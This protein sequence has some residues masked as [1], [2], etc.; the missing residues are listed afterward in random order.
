MGA[1]APW[2]RDVNP[3][4]RFLRER[5]KSKP[6]GRGGQAG[7]DNFVDNFNLAAQARHGAEI[8]CRPG[9]IFRCAGFVSLDTQRLLPLVFFVI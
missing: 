1:G 2:F 3:D 8:P 5:G 9:L 4:S 7:V 6:E